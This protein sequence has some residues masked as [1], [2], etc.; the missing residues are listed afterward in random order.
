MHDCTKQLP[1]VKITCISSLETVIILNR[2]FN[3]NEKL[4]DKTKDKTH[5]M[6]INS[7][8]N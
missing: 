1:I 4:E 5:M 7:E 8:N 3:R 6:L 2:K